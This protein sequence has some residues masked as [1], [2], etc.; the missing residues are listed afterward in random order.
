MTNTIARQLVPALA[1]SA[2]LFLTACETPTTGQVSITLD[3]S[4]YLR[5]EE[6]IVTVAGATEKLKKDGATLGAYEV[7]AGHD[8]SDNDAYF[9]ADDETV[10]LSTPSRPGSHEVRFYSKIGKKDDGTLLARA[11]FTVNGDVAV[12]VT[13]DKETYARGEEIVV[14]LAGI[15]KRMNQDSAVLTI[16]AADSAPGDDVTYGSSPVVAGESTVEFTTP[17]QTGS[18]EAR[19]YRKRDQNADTLAARVPFTVSGEVNVTM[20][21]DK[22]TYTRGEEIVAALAGVTGR[23]KKDGAFVGIYE[24]KAG[25]DAAASS[26]YNPVAGDSEVELTAPDRSG[27]YEVRIYRRGDIKNDATLAA[28]TPFTV[29]RGRCDSKSSSRRCR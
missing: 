25:H 6:I 11:P 24:A 27:S 3:K 10:A 13:L 18:Y 8:N 28:R 7:D 1:A 16:H 14:T 9:H 15:T 23:M 20:K 19:L 4:T 21:L 26:F 2:V 12:S 22:K 29:K 5:G 17:L